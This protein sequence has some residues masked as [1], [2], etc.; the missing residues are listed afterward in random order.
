MICSYLNYRAKL[1]QCKHIYM[2]INII[3]S[4][5]IKRNSNI[6]K[7]F[8][9]ENQ[10]KISYLFTKNDELISERNNMKK[11]FAIYQEKCSKYAFLQ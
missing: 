6:M 5:D 11:D 8:Q 9:L 1:C 10:I 2:I 7:Y 3:F 4:S